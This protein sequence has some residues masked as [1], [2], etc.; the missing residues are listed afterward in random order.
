MQLNVDKERAQAFAS[1]ALAWLAQQNVPPTPKNFELAYNYVSAAQPDLKQAIES[2]TV[3]GG[4]VDS[5]VM[6][7][8]HDRFF[9]A[10]KNGEAMSQVSEKITT[11]LDAVLRLL[12]TAGKDHSAYGKTLS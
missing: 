9:R 5:G 7:L 12:E 3:N 2:L 6:T 8:F 10:D 1:D 4:K 11:E